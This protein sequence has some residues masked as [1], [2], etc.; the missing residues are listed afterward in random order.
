MERIIAVGDSLNVT[1]P[2]NITFGAFHIGDYRVPYF[3]S[4]MRAQQADEYLNLVTDDPKYARQDWKIEEL[5]QREISYPRI[6]DIADNY[7]NPDKANRSPFFNS[8]TVVLVPNGVSGGQNYHPPAKHDNYEFYIDVGPIGITYYKNDEYAQYPAPG[9]FGILQ[10]NRDEVYGVAIDGQHRLAALKH[11]C[12]HNPHAAKKLFVSIIFLVIDPK[13]GFL[14]PPGEK[15]DSTTYMR[16]IFIDLNKHSVPVSRARNIL[17]DDLDPMALFVKSL[18]SPSLAYQKTDRKNEAGFHIGTNGEFATCLPLDIV[19]WH[20]EAK[21]KVD[22][23][24]Y[25]TS[26]LGV[27]WIVNTVLKKCHLLSSLDIITRLDPDDENYYG[28]LK[29]TFWKW[30]ISWSSTIRDR[31]TKCEEHQKPFNLTSQELDSLVDEFVAKWAMPITRL[32]TTT[33]CYAGLCRFRIEKDIISPQFGQWFQIKTDFQSA[34]KGKESDYYK[35][36]L[37][38]VVD[39]LKDEGVLITE[40]E[41]DVESIEQN[42]KANK[43]LFFLV[44]QRA[45]VY[46]LIDLLN[47]KK[48]TQW[49][50]VSEVG[51]ET[52]EKCVEDFCSYY[53]VTAINELFSVYSL[54]SD[55]LFEKSCKVTRKNY[56]NEASSL[57]KE[58]WAGSLTKRDNPKEMDFSEAAAQRGSKWFTFL[59]HL[60]WF[61]K[62]NQGDDRITKAW[63]LNSFEDPGLLV[64]LPFGSE[65]TTCFGKLTS[66]QAQNDAPMEFLAQGYVESPDENP[67]EV[68]IAAKAAAKERIGYLCDL[69]IEA[70]CLNESL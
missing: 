46:S 40:F 23:G 58:F 53:L 32:L 13:V 31:L 24:P 10:W 18:L 38:S 56:T 16:S 1:T 41:K 49:A 64:E 61:L 47:D 35:H 20:S 62:S 19:D 51:L 2:T 45:L 70:G 33:A 25:L 28:K 7:L 39:T 34:K 54:H 29:K 44:G 57:W 8:L 59:A 27:D 9:T 4:V 6:I 5:F 50:E 21:S 52:F 48:I 55:G 26:I 67:A 65:I 60:Y 69:F 63:I 15:F 68:L 42:V 17:L 66:H 30:P 43:I 11:L 3:T 36:K 22:D 37:D 12:K 14:T